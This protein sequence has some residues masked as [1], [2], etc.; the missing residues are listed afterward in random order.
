MNNS[1][2]FNDK[3]R[4]NEKSRLA[5][6]SSKKLKDRANADTPKSGKNTHRWWGGGALCGMHTLLRLPK[7]LRWHQ[8]PQRASSAAQIPD[9]VR[10]ILGTAPKAQP[11]YAGVL[12]EAVKKNAIGVKC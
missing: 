4:R 6:S 9:A 12:G 2:T 3:I 10:G 1:D 8:S 11:T 7:L 5:V